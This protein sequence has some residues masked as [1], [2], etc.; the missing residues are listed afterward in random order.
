MCGL[1]FP[2]RDF[3]HDTAP[4]ILPEKEDAGRAGQIEFRK[5]QP[6]DGTIPTDQSRGVEVADDS[7]TFLVSVG[8]QGSFT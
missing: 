3:G 1:P 2:Q 6:V 4:A 5:K 7:V 8:R